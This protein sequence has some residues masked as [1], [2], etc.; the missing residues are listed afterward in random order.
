MTSPTPR[1][2]ITPRITR[3]RTNSSY[4][5]SSTIRNQIEGRAAQAAAPDYNG[6]YRAGNGKPG[7]TWVN[8]QGER[9]STP[10]YPSSTVAGREATQEQNR[11]LSQEGQDELAEKRAATMSAW[12][13]KQAE[14]RSARPMT[15]DGVD[16]KPFGM[17]VN[18]SGTKI[19]GDKV[20]D[21]NGKDITRTVRGRVSAQQ[22]AARA[23]FSSLDVDVQP[24]LTFIMSYG[25]PLDPTTG[26][27]RKAA[28]VDDF[29]NTNKARRL[30]A[31]RANPKQPTQDAMSIAEG[32]RW[33][34]QLSV[35]DPATYNNW[36]VAMRNAGYIDGRDEQ[37]P[38]NTWSDVVG[39]AFAHA[40]KDAAGAA[41]EG[42]ERTLME[43]L[44]ARGQGLKDYLAQEDAYKPVDRDYMDP[45]ALAATARSAAEEVLGRSLSDEEVARFNSRFRGL[46]DGAYDQIDA[47][48]RAK[49]GAR[50]AAPNASGQAEEFIRGDEFN[51]DRG[52][53]L[54]GTYMDSLNRL[55][56]G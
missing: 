35:K 24:D 33:L 11:R 47:A 7:D 27:D 23:V 30:Q 43:L 38:L 28:P 52:K 48:G 21:E 16:I 26:E 55:L 20:L 18:A 42:E 51:S 8:A 25:K 2:S 44:E 39:T 29:L 49:Q 46:E 10:V 17:T 31:E 15:Q 37:L 54:V 32:V 40:A 45:A 6:P 36:V 56:G 3:T 53:Q 34:R 1:G 41:A 13:K 22:S 14:A 12:Q 19:E 9:I 5:T 50:V 4:G